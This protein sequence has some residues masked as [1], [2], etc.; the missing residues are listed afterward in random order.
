M[1]IGEKPRIVRIRECAVVGYDDPENHRINHDEYYY[2][3]YGIHPEHLPVRN[4]G[5]AKVRYAYIEHTSEPTPLQ[6]LHELEQNHLE[7]PD[8]AE[9]R[10]FHLQNP[11]KRHGG[12]IISLVGDL[13]KHSDG[14]RIVCH[15]ASAGGLDLGWYG[16]SYHWRPGNRIL[17]VEKRLKRF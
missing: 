17:A 5:I 14:Y 15:H 6:V 13:E 10:Y 1:L 16:T 8:I 4:R 7:R 11:R 2:V 3:E 12:A 9:A